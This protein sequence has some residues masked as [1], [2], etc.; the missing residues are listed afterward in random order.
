MRASVSIRLFSGRPLQIITGSHI[1]PI[2]D[3]IGN[4]FL[5]FKFGADFQVSD[6]SFISSGGPYCQIAIPCFGEYV[7]GFGRGVYIGF[8]NKCRRFWYIINL[9]P[10]A[11]LTADFFGNFVRFEYGFAAYF[12]IS[13]EL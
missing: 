9:I 10:F 1:K 12:G 13:Y 6:T 8:C 4:L 3:L 5:L 2:S 11:N 7:N